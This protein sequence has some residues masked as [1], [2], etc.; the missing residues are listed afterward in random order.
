VAKHRRHAA[1]PQATD[2]TAGAPA[3]TSPLEVALYGVLASLVAAGVLLVG[4]QPMWQA[5]MIVA[6]AVVLLV[7][8]MR[9]STGSRHGRRRRR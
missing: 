2:A 6:V 8:V 9:L 4:G 5:I 1:S 7:L 3:G